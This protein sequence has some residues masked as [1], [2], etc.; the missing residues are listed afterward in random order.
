MTSSRPKGSIIFDS[1]VSDYLSTE[2]INVL[3]E[4]IAWRLVRQLKVRG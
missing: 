4:T 2:D 3:C 1:N